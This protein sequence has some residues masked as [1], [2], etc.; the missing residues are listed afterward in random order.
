MQALATDRFLVPGDAAH[1]VIV[2]DRARRVVGANAYGDRLLGEGDGLSAVAG[3]LR[4]AAP[5]GTRA[6]AQ[7]VTAAI[8]GAGQVGALRLPRPSGKPDLEVLVCGYEPA[9][10]PTAAAVLVTDP[11][12]ASV[13]GRLPRLLAELYGLTPAESQVAADLAGG[14]TPQEIADRRRIRPATVRVHLK[15]VFAKTGTARQAQLVQR[16]LRGPLGAI[17]WD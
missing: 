11:G 9:A 4:A 3:T 17:A 14:R 7:R 8:A 16:I 12:R 15:A 1:G 6:L 10:E 2:V 13:A 5:G